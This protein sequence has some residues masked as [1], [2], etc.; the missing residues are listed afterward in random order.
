[1]DG[2]DLRNK[3][4]DVDGKGG[5]L[6][7]QVVA[8]FATFPLLGWR[9]AM[10]TGEHKE[11]CKAGAGKQNAL[12]AVSMVP[13]PAHLFHWL[14]RSFSS[15]W[16]AI[17][18]H[19]PAV[20]WFVVCTWQHLVQPWLGHSPSM[21]QV[22]G[23]SWPERGACDSCSQCP[24]LVDGGSSARPNANSKRSCDRREQSGETSRAEHRGDE[25]QERRTRR[26]G[27]DRVIYAKKRS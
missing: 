17:A 16:Q 21:R 22:L 10:V 6:H 24:P 11:V 26:A 23:F 25:E 20:D 9:E 7:E 27:K 1:M 8:Q 19:A 5:C 18:R 3:S 2:D 4:D 15:V 12:A 14:H 13:F